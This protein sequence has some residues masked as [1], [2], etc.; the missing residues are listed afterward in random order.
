MYI[1]YFGCQYKKQTSTE[2]PRVYCTCTRYDLCGHQVFVIMGLT[3]HTLQPTVK[4]LI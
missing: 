2:T 3:F 1:V 4:F